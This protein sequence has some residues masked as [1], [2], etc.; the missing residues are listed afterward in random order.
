MATQSIIY[1]YTNPAT[2]C[3]QIKTP[4]YLMG[5][6]VSLLKQHFSN[7][8]RLTLDKSTF[9]YTE[10]QTQCDS[11]LYIG[12][13]DNLDF[14]TVSKRPA[15]IVDLG[16]MTFPKD[17]IAD[18][19]GYNADEGALQFMDRT[20]TTLVFTCVS[21]KSLES[22]SLA[23]EVRYFFNT[24]KLFIAREY[25]MDEIR[26]N[27]I[28]GYQ[29]LEG[30]YKEVSATRVVVGMSF[31]QNYSVTKE[32]LKISAVDFEAVVSQSFRL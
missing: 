32:A 19:I 2:A 27:G 17:A 11:N 26:V 7:P 20:F 24:Y 18:R 10:D 29:R 8:N 6:G 3:C 14:K 30:D 9:L 23:G 5:L 21:D 31:Q 16:D 1:P 15:V 13:R 28:S 4:I 22:W 25:C 12:F